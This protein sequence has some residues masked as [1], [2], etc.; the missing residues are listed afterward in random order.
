MEFKLGDKVK[1][2]S[3]FYEGAIGTLTDYK[4]NKNEYFFDGTLTNS[5]KTYSVDVW[6]LANVLEKI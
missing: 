1:I 5:S 2:I 6:V 3:G 4:K